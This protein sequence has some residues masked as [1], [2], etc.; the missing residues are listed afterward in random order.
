MKKEKYIS[1]ETKI[2]EF[3]QEDIIIT[4]FNVQ[5]KGIDT[6]GENGIGYVEL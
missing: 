4:S 6:A 2:I 5:G 1:P 3:S